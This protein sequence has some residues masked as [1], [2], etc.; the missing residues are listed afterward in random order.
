[1]ADSL[2]EYILQSKSHVVFIMEQDS[3]S[4][5]YKK[6][7]NNF[8]YEISITTFVLYNLHNTKKNNIANGKKLY[9]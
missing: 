7:L 1:M 4:I 6:T 5:F 9:N 3:C 2:I 8:G